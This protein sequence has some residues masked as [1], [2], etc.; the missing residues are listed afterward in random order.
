MKQPENI[1]KRKNVMDDVVSE[2]SS[3]L[4]GIEEKYGLGFGCI[5]EIYYANHGRPDNG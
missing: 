5:N 3:F 2:L 1:K 4:S